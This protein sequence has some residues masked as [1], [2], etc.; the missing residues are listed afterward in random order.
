MDT[1]YYFDYCITSEHGSHGLI[2]YRIVLKQ[3]EF[4]ISGLLLLRSRSYHSN[5]TTVTTGA[6]KPDHAYLMIQ[7]AKSSNKNR[8]ML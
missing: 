4:R 5:P 3:S 1:L 6:L 2:E 7:E 8:A